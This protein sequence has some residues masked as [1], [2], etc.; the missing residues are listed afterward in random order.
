MQQHKGMI[1]YQDKRILFFPFFYFQLL[2]LSEGFVYI[3]V[4]QKK[5]LIADSKLVKDSVAQKQISAND[6]I[7]IN[8]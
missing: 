6:K 3:T 2:D 4:F 1:F 7:S 5:K 8:N